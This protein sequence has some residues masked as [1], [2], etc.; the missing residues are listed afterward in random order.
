MSFMSFVGGSLES[1]FMFD[2]V[3]EV[4]CEV[5]MQDVDKFVMIGDD[6]LVTFA[7]F[8]QSFSKYW[9]LVGMTWGTTY[10]L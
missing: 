4:T 10:P 6:A 3:V 2:D 7:S 1:N 8:L 5:A 9:K